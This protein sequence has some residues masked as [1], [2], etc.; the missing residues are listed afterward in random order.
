M[1]R[2]CNVENQKCYRKTPIID[3]AVLSAN[4]KSSTSTMVYVA[5]FFH[6]ALV[7]HTVRQL[8]TNINTHEKSRD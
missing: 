4:V 8:N 7:K 1:A 6:L 3:M 2:T 5:G